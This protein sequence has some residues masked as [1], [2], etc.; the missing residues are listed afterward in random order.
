M[1]L[2]QRRWHCRESSQ[3]PCPITSAKC[4]AEPD[5]VF[6]IFAFLYF[7]IFVFFYKKTFCLLRR[8]AWLN[9]DN[10]V[11]CEN[12]V[13]LY[14]LLK[15]Y[16]SW[17]NSIFRDT[18]CDYFSKWCAEQDSDD[19]DSLNVVSFVKCCLVLSCAQIW[20]WDTSEECRFQRIKRAKLAEWLGFVRIF[21]RIVT[22]LVCV[23]VW[24]VCKC[25]GWE[26][27]AVCWAGN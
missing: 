22:K 4:V 15:D 2:E 24:S 26:D 19:W 6:C 20:C 14:I 7:C 9:L 18:F 13:S 21:C 16:I 25:C 11:S 3:T 10:C 12:H 23:C 5:C 1:W 17:D 8:L 27:F